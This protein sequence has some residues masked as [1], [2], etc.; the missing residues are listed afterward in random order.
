MRKNDARSFVLAWLLCIACIGNAQNMQPNQKFGKPTQEEL[1]MKDYPADKD[2]P[3]VVLYSQRTT[4][5][6]IKRQSLQVVNEYKYR[7]KVL[8]SEDS[9]FQSYQFEHKG[10]NYRS[11]GIYI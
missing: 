5:Y 3:A 1:T 2:A 10:N 9:L 11:K 7:L 6:E 4:F 8:K